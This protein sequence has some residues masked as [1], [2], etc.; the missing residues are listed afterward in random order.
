[1][2]R[3]HVKVAMRAWYLG[4]LLPIAA[5]AA[6]P[7]DAPTRPLAT[8]TA[9]ASPATTGSKARV[10]VQTGTGPHFL[11]ENLLVDYCLA[12][13]SREPFSIDVG[14]DY[15]GSSRS[16][17]FI[18]EVRDA[19][20]TLVPDPDPE[21]YNL[22]GLGYSPTLQPGE[23]WCQ[24]LPLVRYARI[25]APGK[26]SLRVTHDL[27]WPEGT[28]PA[29][30]GTIELVMPNAVQAEAVVARMESLPCDPNT[31]AGKVS[32]PYADFSALRYDVYVAPLLRRAR[33]GSLDAISGLSW[34]P[35]P[36]ATRALI[37]LLQASDPKAR[38][39]AVDGLNLRLPDPALAGAL[40]PRNP[41]G[42][43][44]PAQRKY[45]SAQAW[46]PGFA[47]EVRTAARRLLASADVG[48]LQPGAFMLEAVGTAADAPDLV[49][50]LTR[51]ILRTQTEPR[52]AGVYPVPRGACQELLRAAQILLGRGLRAPVAPKSEGELA[53]WL[54]AVGQ[55]AHP[56]GWEASL[57]RALRHPVP[58]LR[59]LA[60]DNTP[61]ALP[62]R[63][64]PAVSANLAHADIDVQIAATLLV[65][66]AKLTSLVPGIIRII[67]RAKDPTQLTIAS[68]AAYELGARTAR[69]L[70]LA[71]R[72]AEPDMFNAALGE[73][74]GLLDSHGYSSSGSP[75]PHA[76]AQLVERW[77][78]FIEQH[79]L[80]IQA[81]T[82]IPLDENVPVDLVPPNWKLQHADGTDWP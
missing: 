56:T 24:S 58:Y 5:C 61:A 46:Q 63:L 2:G 19:A 67:E 77:R 31:S 21:P 37:G 6:H 13:T 36:D 78:A 50:A 40:G 44:L 35:T 48:D 33:K 3:L 42:N 70:A 51:A 75:P 1:M 20:G 69:G 81:G 55:G 68:N 9:S 17:R 7:E 25:D 60:L 59:A 11:G 49:S 22:G 23:K 8:A 27:G 73:L 28:A 29:G 54:L 72:L 64:E 62:M 15:R 74:A 57:G 4:A 16:L 79:R 52:E 41:L 66:R 34:I 76:G 10:M 32:R 53:V 45:L 65:E 30:Q 71:G 18:V 12:N 39:A 26:Y 82:R 43:E 80:E 38:R 47:D 14:G